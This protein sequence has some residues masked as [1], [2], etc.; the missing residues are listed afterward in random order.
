M[1]LGAIVLGAGKLNEGDTNPKSL[2]EFKGESLIEISLS[3]CQNSRYVE[4]VCALVPE[5]LKAIA[6]RFSKVKYVK[7]SNSDLIKGIYKALDNLNYRFIVILPS[8]IPFISRNVLDGF[9]EECFKKEAKGYYPILEKE[10]LEKKFPG[11]Q[12][13]YA[14]LREGTFTGGNIFLIEAGVL[15][16]NEEF[17]KNIY[18]ARKNPYALAKILGVVFLIKGVLGFLTV[19]E[20]EKKVSKIVDAPIR[21]VNTRFVE[22][23]IDIDKQAD[24]DF[25]NSVIG[26]G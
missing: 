22:M 17:L 15:K 1:Q 19:E 25:V 10:M 5:E 9:I 12:R 2:L 13:T 3:T 14:K 26:G 7:H 4:K 20:A 24:V 11:T 16:R 8:D 23:G 21:A 6:E 18:N